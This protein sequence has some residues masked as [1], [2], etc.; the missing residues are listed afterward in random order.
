[1]TLKCSNA[2]KI[3]KHTL[4]IV[5]VNTFTPTTVTPTRITDTIATFIDHIYYSDGTKHDN[6]II[7]GGNLWCDI[8]DHL[9]NFV[10]LQDSFKK[11]KHDFTTLP[12]VRLHTS[13]NVGKFVKSVTGIN[14]T[15][16]Y[17]IENP[18]RPTA[19]NFFN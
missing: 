13:K 16:L 15:E 2:T 17:E 3:A 11:N 5:I 6:S 9:P 14:W 4:I 12:S 7:T 8:S 19:Y 18:N 10:F 1:M